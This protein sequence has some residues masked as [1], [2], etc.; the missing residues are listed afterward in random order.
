MIQKLFGGK[1]SSSD[2]SANSKSKKNGDFF[3]ELEEIETGKTAEP[4]NAKQPE[5]S[6]SVIKEQPTETKASKKSKAASVKEAS[7]A[8]KILVAPVTTPIQASSNNSKVEP[9]EVAFASGEHGVPSTVS[10]RRPGPSLN[11]FKDM[12]S[13]IKTPKS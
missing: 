7:T 8:S 12:A 6:P 13:Q 9:T 1:K 2:K 11:L 4:V 10:R 5:V 3:L